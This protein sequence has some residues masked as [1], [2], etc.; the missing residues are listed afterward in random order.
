MNRLALIDLDKVV[1][2][3]TARMARAEQ[4][5]REYLSG[6]GMLASL[7]YLPGTEAYE[8]AW[9]AAQEDE[10]SI[11]SLYEGEA[12]KQAD[13]KE[14]TNIYWR[15]AFTPDLVA[16]DTLIDGVPD[17]IKRIEDVH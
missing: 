6:K 10:E 2:D 16:L 15:T 14:A 11:F 17:A 1:C 9:K 12:Y 5:K 8:V 4:A 13:M 7:G 3:N